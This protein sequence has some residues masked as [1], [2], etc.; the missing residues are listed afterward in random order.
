M[1][2]LLRGAWTPPSCRLDCAVNDRPPLESNAIQIP[3]GGCRWDCDRTVRIA[4]RPIGTKPNRAPTGQYLWPGS[5]ANSYPVCRPSAAS[6]DHSRPSRY[7]SS[8]TRSVAH[9][10]RLSTTEKETLGVVDCAMFR[11]GFA[12][13]RK[14]PSRLASSK[15]K[16]NH[17]K[18]S[19]HFSITINS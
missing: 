10:T 2:F 19:T 6:C 15:G 9:S 13:R 18:N 5:W 11:K 1:S 8:A 16:K 17:R 7:C 3:I 12:R 14:R 4:T